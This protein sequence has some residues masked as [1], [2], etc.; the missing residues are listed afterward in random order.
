MTDCEEE[1]VR[2]RGEFIISAI[3]ILVLA[4][5]ALED[6]IQGYIAVVGILGVAS[7]LGIF[8]MVRLRKGSGKK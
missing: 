7:G 6:V 2:A 4:W 5:L 3:I 1:V 8:E